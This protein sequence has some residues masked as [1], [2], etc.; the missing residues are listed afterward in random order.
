MKNRIGHAIAVVGAAT[1]LLFGGVAAT[2]ASN[3]ADDGPGHHSKGHHHKGQHHKNGHHK[4]GHHKRGHR[5]HNGKG[6]QSK[7]G[8]TDDGVGHD[9]GDDHGQHGPD[10]D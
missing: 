6:Q 8:G 2:Q 5:G 1:A 3:G 7:S 4:N 9:V 10:H